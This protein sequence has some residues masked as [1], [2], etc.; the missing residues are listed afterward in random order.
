M[1]SKPDLEASYRENVTRGAV[2]LDEKEPGWW[3]RID[4]ERLD[5]DSLTDCIIGQLYGDF[6]DW[7]EVRDNSEAASDL[8]F[9]AYS[10][11]ELRE[12]F[13]YYCHDVGGDYAVLWALWNEEIAERKSRG[14]VPDPA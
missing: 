5:M 11:Y 3:E 14:T 13:G 9:D 12:K 10:D 2:W 7:E 4:L 8:G 6:W 1:S